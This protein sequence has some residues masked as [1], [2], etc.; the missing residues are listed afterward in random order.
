MKKPTYSYTVH[1]VFLVVGG[2]F[3]EGDRYPH[4]ATADRE[5]ANRWVEEFQADPMNLGIPEIVSLPVHCAENLRES[6]QRKI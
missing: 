3:H 4:Y 2:P 1:L 6:P 5:D